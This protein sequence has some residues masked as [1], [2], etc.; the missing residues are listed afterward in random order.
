MSKDQPSKERPPTVL[1]V[2]EP[3]LWHVLSTKRPHLSAGIQ[4]IM[5][6]IIKIAPKNAVISRDLWDNLW[7]DTRGKSGSRTMFA[8]H[9]DTVETRGRE[10]RTPIFYSKS[11]WIDTNGKAILGADDGAGVAMLCSLMHKVPALYIFT[12]GEEC[13][14]AA[15]KATAGDARLK[16]IDRCIAFDRKGTKDIVADQ[17][18]GILASK[19]F[20]TALADAIDMGHSWAVGSYTDSSEFNGSVKEIVN[21]SIGYE[22]A[23]TVNEKFNYAYFKK[24]RTACLKLDWEALPTVGPDLT[25]TTYRHGGWKR[26]QGWEDDLERYYDRLWAE[27]EDRKSKPDTYYSQ[28]SYN[29]PLPF[30]PQTDQPTPWLTEANKLVVALGFDPKIDLALLDKI[31]ES[32]R[33][34]HAMG[35][36]EGRKEVYNLNRFSQGRPRDLQP[37]KDITPPALAQP[38]VPD[39]KAEDIHDATMVENMMLDGGLMD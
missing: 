3:I 35:K 5:L 26:G 21:I 23:H 4:E 29:P 33:I 7:I 18:R 16:D 22:S 24:L 19:D 38:T 31:S 2:P 13:G 8:A 10:G 11:Q 28:R 14:G 17:V 6:H 20:V 12:Q 15:A 1:E 27:R 39:I 25:A 34:M 30:I 36:V 37:I 32:M 9:L